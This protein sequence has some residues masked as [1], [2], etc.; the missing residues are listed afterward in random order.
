MVGMKSSWQTNLLGMAAIL[1]LGSVAGPAYMLYKTATI[2]GPDRG[3]PMYVIVYAIETEAAFAA[4][5]GICL[6]ISCVALT[7][8]RSVRAAIQTGFL[9]AA[10][11]LLGMISYVVMRF[12][13]VL[14]AAISSGL[15]LVVISAAIFIPDGRPVDAESG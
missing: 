15:T 9:G 14:A 7:N 12:P 1:S 5:L 2:S 4:I 13:Y 6:F 11:C 3:D 8:R 10:C